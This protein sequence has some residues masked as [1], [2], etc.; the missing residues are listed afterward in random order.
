MRTQESSL[1]DRVII[2]TRYPT[3]G[4]TKKRL[5]PALGP[6]GAADLHREMTEN[7]VTVA[8]RAVAGK[9][10]S[11]EVCLDGGSA[12]QMER[13]LGPGLAFSAQVHRGFGER[14]LTAFEKAFQ[15]G[16]VRVVLL[17]TDIP[18]VS[19]K[20]VDQAFEALEN[21][22]LVLGPSED[23][24]YWL[25]GLKKSA[26]L[27]QGIAWG[28]E[29]VL[30]QTLD[31]AREEGLTVH[32]LET[33]TDVDREEQL[34]RLMP[35]WKKGNPYISVIIPTLNEEKH[36]QEV[37]RVAETDGVECVVV[38]GGSM[39]RT[40]ALA[41]EAG[42]RVCSSTPGRASQQNRGAEIAR[43]KVFLFLHADTVLPVDYVHQ[44]FETLMDRRVALGAF[45][46]RTDLDHPVM[47]GIE[48]LTNFRS[49]VFGLPYG[50]QGLFIRRSVFGR[51]RGFP[52]VPL[53]EDLFFV[54]T[55][56][57]LGRIKIAPGHVV[58]SARRWRRVGLLRTTLINQIIV[59]GCLLGVPV[60]RLV[61]LYKKY[62]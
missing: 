60:R 51:V 48:S 16:A 11:V 54:R 23:G 49:R 43:G 56:K 20:Y 35:D 55:L 39:D 8:R 4:K 26:D 50:D 17:G 53:A 19:E 42:A 25:L 32:L 30:E 40:V 45:R 57:R 7:T 14:L 47:K 12:A 21:N 36:V 59:A 33:L 15:G 61:P 18:E 9:P 31:S 27:F 62:A 5:I 22:D 6:V 10:M 29:R 24:G 3:P 28:T 38:D 1:P 34:E 58:T 44:V 13:W 41:E 52:E 2:F 46:F 37:I